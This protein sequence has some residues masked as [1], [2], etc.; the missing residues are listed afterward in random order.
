MA[1]VLPSFGR[2]QVVGVIARGGGIIRHNYVGIDCKSLL[3]ELSDCL[4]TNCC[5]HLFHD[6]MEKEGVFVGFDAGGWL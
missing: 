1:R 4:L 3:I 5:V 6:L 2:S